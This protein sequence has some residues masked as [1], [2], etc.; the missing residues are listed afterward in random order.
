MTACDTYTQKFEGT[1]VSHMM[2]TL[3]GSVER[4][5]GMACHAMPCHV[6]H[7]GSRHAMVQVHTYVAAR[8]LSL[9]PV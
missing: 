6:S 1:L 4:T 5:H 8:F 7:V 2:I 9:E 3:C